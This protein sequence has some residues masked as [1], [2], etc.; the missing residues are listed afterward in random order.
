MCHAPCCGTPE[1]FKKLID[2]GYAERL[3]YDNLPGGSHMLKPSLKG[4]EGKMSP[5][6]V[7]SS[8]GC[9]FWVNGL[10]ELHSTGLKPTSGKLAHHS[11]SEQKYKQTEEYVNDSWGDRKGTEVIERWKKI[12]GN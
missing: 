5:W 11:L 1:D 2:A 9:T 8:D 3:M 7:L 10:C 4:Y 6:H 12:T